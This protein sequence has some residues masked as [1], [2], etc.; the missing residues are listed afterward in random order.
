MMV[1]LQPCFAVV[2]E[3]VAGRVVDDEKQLSPR[4]FDEVLEELEEGLAV[5]DR[6]ERN[7]SGVGLS[8]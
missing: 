4:A 5:E 3:V 2:L 1:L 6:C 8:A 7:R